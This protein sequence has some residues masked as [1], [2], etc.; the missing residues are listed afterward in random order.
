MTRHRP[1]ITGY[2]CFLAA[3]LSAT[4]ADR[5]WPVYL[6]GAGNS[7]YSELKQLNRGNVRRMEQAWIYR[8][9]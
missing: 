3:C 8:K 6:G 2:A 4:A 5:N 9:R 1:L 7:H